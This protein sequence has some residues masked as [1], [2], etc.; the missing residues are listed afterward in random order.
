MMSTSFS[1]NG[2][3]ED[4][5]MGILTSYAHHNPRVRKDIWKKQYLALPRWKLI[6]LIILSIRGNPSDNCYYHQFKE[7][8][9]YLKELSYPQL[10]QLSLRGRPSGVIFDLNNAWNSVNIEHQGDRT[11]PVR[12]WYVA[13][14]KAIA[15]TE[16][17]TYAANP[18]ADAVGYCTVVS[19]DLIREAGIVSEETLDLPKMD[20]NTNSTSNPWRSTFFSESWMGHE[21]YSH[22]THLSYYD[23][24]WTWFDYYSSLPTY[25]G[26]PAIHSDRVFGQ[27]HW[28]KNPEKPS[29]KFCAPRASPVCK[30]TKYIQQGE[31]EIWLSSDTDQYLYEF[32]GHCSYRYPEGSCKGYVKLDG[33]DVSVQLSFSRSE[34]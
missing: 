6:D 23:E 10:V 14:N 1:V 11:Q 28:V 33:E 25:Q 31:G 15:G 9:D 29:I 22:F 24:K 26:I 21:V 16:L 2:V 34:G 4:D 8:A 20:Q 27:L 7:V 5:M 19:K 18:K 17:R 32:R 3:T 12:L 30:H 13:F